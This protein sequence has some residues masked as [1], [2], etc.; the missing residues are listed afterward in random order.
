M[1]E[2]LIEL[3]ECFKNATAQQKQ[4][5]MQI[6]GVSLFAF[7][8][9]K[10]NSTKEPWWNKASRTQ[11]R[12]RLKKQQ[13]QQSKQT[14]LQ[15]KPTRAFREQLAKLTA[16][17]EKA[18]PK[19]VTKRNL[20]KII[21][22]KPEGGIKIKEIDEVDLIIPEGVDR[23]SYGQQLKLEVVYRTTAR[24]SAKK[25]RKKFGKGNLKLTKKAKRK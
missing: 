14:F 24:K 6:I 4:E 23:E 11:S 18:E 2:N 13:K 16:K 5:A 17:A 1:K 20:K 7:S 8:R 15:P 12:N 21:L 3:H 10:S 9:K 19:E 25:R 22:P